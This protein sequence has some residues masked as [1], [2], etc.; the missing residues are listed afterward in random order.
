MSKETI[1][2]LLKIKENIFI[3]FK[4]YLKII[5][6]ILAI[7]LFAFYF[8]NKKDKNIE[9]GKLENGN[10]E[11]IVSVSG[12]VNPNQ[13]SSLTFEKSGKIESIKVSVG[14]NVHLGQVLA[15]INGE[16]DYASVLNAEAGV[17]SA[18]ANLQDLLNGS[19]DLDISIKKEA[20]DAALNTLNTANDSVNDSLRGVYFSMTDILNNKLNNLFSYSYYYKLNYNSCDQDLQG[21]LETNRKTLDGEMLNLKN[22]LDTFNIDG[23]STDS[24]NEKVKSIIDI[25]YKESLN[26]YEF[27]NN[28]DKLLSLPCSISDPVVSS[29]KNSLSLAKTSINTNISTISSLRSQI[30]T[31][32]NNVSSAEDY[33]SQIQAAPS[34]EKIKSLRA[35]LDSARANLISAKAD[36]DKNI[37]VAPFDGTVTGVNINLGEISSPGTSAISLI[38]SN[39]LELKIKLSEIDLVKVKTGDKARVFLDTY[40]NTVSFPGVVAQVFPAATKEGNTS[41][42]YAKIDFTSQ[43]DRLKSGM[44]SS[45]DIITTSR[46][47]ADYILAKYLKVDGKNNRVKVVKDIS[48][49]KDV[50]INDNDKNIIWKDVEV[51]MRDVNGKIEIL[52]GINKEDILVPIQDQT[53]TSTNN[54]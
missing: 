43:D 54:N 47:S 14:D 37:L 15:T 51:G 17:R 38:S 46:E 2:K 31:L 39:N 16:N 19:S 20:L 5:I 22:S 11:E 27:L 25:Y 52:S 35:S 53:S 12:I 41:V 24:A 44:N 6:I 10:L 32:K 49:L 1:E 28:T 8:F 7:I 4:K 13:E 29:Y 42:Y 40:G 45:A 30:N 48:K 21:K 34:A 26:L 36:N 23:L 50:S 18:E 33:L 9:F 3:F